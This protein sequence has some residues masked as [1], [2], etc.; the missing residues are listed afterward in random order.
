VCSHVRG[1]NL[2]HPGH[3]CKHDI[4]TSDATGRVRIGIAPVLSVERAVLVPVM[5]EEGVD[6]ISLEFQ[7]ADGGDVEVIAASGPT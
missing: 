6:G 5:V 7:S 4:V 2:P 3:V 1:L